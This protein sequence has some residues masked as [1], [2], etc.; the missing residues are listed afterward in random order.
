MVQTLERLIE[1]ASVRRTVSTQPSPVKAATGKAAASTQVAVV[2]EAAADLPRID[3]SML[4]VE[5][6]LHIFQYLP[7]A[8]VVRCGRVCQQWRLAATDATY[9]FGRV[10][11][12]VPKVVT[13]PPPWTVGRGAHA[14]YTRRCRSHHTPP[15]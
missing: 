14:A 5:V 10:A 1:Y 8:A 6:L 3:G 4:P 12:K 2:S 15:N 13:N 7:L 11:D 9:V